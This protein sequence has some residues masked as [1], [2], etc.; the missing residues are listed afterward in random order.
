MI[1]YNRTWLYN[2]QLTQQLSEAFREQLIDENSFRKAIAEKEN[3]LY[4]PNLLIQFG[5]GV[6]TIVICIAVA[7][8][9][10]LSALDSRSLIGFALSFGV[11]CYAALEILVWVKKYFNAGIDN[12]LLIAILIATLTSVSDNDQVLS[13]G[14]IGFIVSAYLSYRFV[15]GL[16]AVFSFGA[17]LLIFVGICLHHGWMNLLPFLLMAISLIVLMV[18]KKL[19]DNFKFIL[20][21]KIFTCL[22]IAGLIAFYAAGNYF[23]IDKLFQSNSSYSDIN[24]KLNAVLAAIFW[25]C[26]VAIPAIYIWYGIRKKDIILLRTGIVL[27]AAAV[28]TIRYYHSFLPIDLALS[29]AGIMLIALS[30]WLIKFLSTAKSGY[31]SKQSNKPNSTLLNLEALILAETFAQTGTH[32]NTN[33]TNFGGGSGGGGGASGAF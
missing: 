22:Y 25:I 16:M 17:L 15:D 12:V 7:A 2:Q 11:L 26:S 27:V 14:I 29:L 31:S 5:M 4:T 1:A 3:Q 33:P 9:V 28:F 13:F 19:K 10:A 32:T 18:A 23:V 8:L 24:I 6:L 21:Q 30:H 20:F